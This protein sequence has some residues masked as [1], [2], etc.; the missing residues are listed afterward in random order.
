MD[1]IAALLVSRLSCNVPNAFS[2]FRLSFYADLGT[3][4]AL[5]FS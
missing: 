4:S 1:K 3:Y 5:R 2:H